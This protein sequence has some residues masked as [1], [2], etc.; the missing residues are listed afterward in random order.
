L[1]GPT[2][3]R[4]SISSWT[5]WAATGSSPAVGPSR[6]LWIAQLG[7]RQGD[8]LAQPLRQ[9][10]ARIVSTIDEIDGAAGLGDPL[11]RVR[12]LV[13]GAEALQV[14]E[15][16]HPQVQARRLAHGGDT[17][18]GSVLRS[19]GQMAGPPPSP[20][21]SSARGACRALAWS[22]SSRPVGSEEAE[23][24]SAA[25]LERDVFEG[26]SF[27][28]SRRQMVDRVHWPAA[29][30]LR[31][32]RV[33]DAHG[34]VIRPKRSARRLAVRH[35][36]RDPPGP[37]APAPPATPGIRGLTCRATAIP[38]PLDPMTGLRRRSRPDQGRNGRSTQPRS[39]SA[40]AVRA[41]LAKPRRAESTS[42]AGHR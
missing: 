5:S 33:L 31:E 21:P 4:P 17:P 39:A 16:A 12:H 36:P 40:P 14:L 20:S 29:V 23:F 28:G 38:V 30:V 22:S 1:G 18:P 32:G 8:A 35:E 7:L 24:L 34:A 2:P 9:R 6:N 3:A 41:R 42:Q 37:I 19:L 11:T 27:T 13:Q 25:N 10:T 26:H 15:H